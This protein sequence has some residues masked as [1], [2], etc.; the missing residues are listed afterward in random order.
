MPLRAWSHLC[1]PIALACCLSQVLE[2]PRD[3]SEGAELDLNTRHERDVL[4]VYAR[5]HT[6]AHAHVPSHACALRQVP[7]HIARCN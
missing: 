3:L 6:C 2:Y 5:A 7:Q 1:T 4:N